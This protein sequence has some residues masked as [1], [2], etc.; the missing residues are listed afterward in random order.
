MII[1]KDQGRGQENLVKYHSS[2][3]DLCLLFRAPSAIQLLSE[4]LLIALDC[5]GHPC[6]LIFGD[7][8]Y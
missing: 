7:Q 6:H 5:L 3:S 8:D 1:V 4:R 2:L